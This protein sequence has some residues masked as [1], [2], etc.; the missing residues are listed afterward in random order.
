ML[1][2]AAAALTGLLFVA[3]SLHP[4]EIMK[5]PLQRVRARN[6]TIAT[7]FLLTEAA[8]ILMPQPPVALGAELALANFLGPVLFPLLFLVRHHRSPP[9]VVALVNGLLGVAGGISLIAQSGGGMYLIVLAYIIQFWDVVMIA[10]S[11][12]TFVHREK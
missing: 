10:W 6:N 7:L 4:D 3:T 5:S 1:G 11:L 2:G 12:L 9:S 8:L